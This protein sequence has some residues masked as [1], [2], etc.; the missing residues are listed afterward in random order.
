MERTGFADRQPRS[1]LSHAGKVPSSSPFPLNGEN[2]VESIENDADNERDARGVSPSGSGRN[3]SGLDDAVFDDLMDTTRQSSPR[4]SNHSED[5][6][7]ELPLESRVGSYTPE[8][9]KSSSY[10]R[11]KIRSPFRNPSSIRALQLETTPPPYFLSSSSSQHRYKLNT[12]SRNST[13]RSTRSYHGPTRSP[14]KTSPA[15]KVKKEYPLVLLHVTILPIVMPY[16]QETMESVL[17]SYIMENWKLLRERVADTVLER[18]ILI[19]HPREDYDLLEERMLE[20]LELKVPRILKCGHFHLEADEADDI[21]ALEGDEYDSDNDLDI[22]GD[23]GRRIRDGRHG[24]GAGQR[25]WDIKIYAANGLMRAGAWA[26]AWNEMER[27]DVEIL[28]WIEDDFRRELDL[29][30]EEERQAP[31]SSSGHGI[32][33]HHDN[34]EASRM[35]DARIREIYGDNAQAYFPNVADEKL[36]PPK[37]AEENETVYHHHHHQADLHPDIPVWTLLQNYLYLAAQDRRNIVIFCLSMFVLFLSTTGPPG[38]GA[39]SPPSPPLQIKDTQI[40]PS[41]SI[42]LPIEISSTLVTPSAISSSSMLS[43]VVIPKQMQTSLA[44]APSPSEDYLEDLMEQMS[45]SA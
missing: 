19:P 28:P 41:S 36:R 20:S 10:S 15:K 38:H 31:L 30:R 40:M 21:T 32:H 42:P 2:L 34:N 16:S 45:E 17:P 37:T 22:C 44:S 33:P 9:E 18:G 12:P 7:S 23:C 4:T 8:R 13:P 3:S 24:S 5:E 14:S 6:I 1:S 35:D 25:R 11:E 39:P 29:R 43:T 26:A 27:V